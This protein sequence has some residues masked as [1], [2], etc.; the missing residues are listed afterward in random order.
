MKDRGK[1]LVVD[2]SSSVRGAM[3]AVLETDFEVEAADSG[4]AALAVLSRFDADLVL[5]DL[6][7][8]GIN[9]YEVCQRI[10]SDSRL[11]SVKVLIVSH[12]TTL[13]E[14]LKGYAAG[15]DDYIMKPFNAQELMAKVCVFMRLKT[16]E[17]GLRQLN[18]QLNEQV[19]VRTQQLIDAER[20]AAIGRYA[21]G[22]V[23]NLNTPLQVIMG[24]AELLSVR[25]SQDRRMMNLRKAAGQMKKIVGAILSTCRQEC[26]AEYRLIDLNQVLRDQVELLR[27][28]PFFKENIQVRWE[29][30]AIPSY[31]GLYHHFSQSLGNLI[32]NAADAMFGHKKPLI[33]IKTAIEPTRIAIAIAD[34]GPG[35]PDSQIHK[36]FDPFFTTKPLTASDERPT[37]TGLGLASAREMIASYGGD[38]QVETQIGRG[39]TFTVRL[40][41]ESCESRERAPL[42]DDSKTGGPCHE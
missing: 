9:G 28:A 39:S 29:L 35:I 11:E 3:R 31:R 15:A 12:M 36:I 22:I 41:L 5:L 23:H 17:D 6:L 13:D 1:I 19:R 16:A 7:M 21:A 2:D 25:H 37:G 14:R 26:A 10:K 20:M 27:A 38:I 8:P 4:E 24:N 40:P 33:T 30:G 34:T 32:K 42:K 18:E